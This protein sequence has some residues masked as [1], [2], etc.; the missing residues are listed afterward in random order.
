MIVNQFS[1]S[2]NYFDS[3]P[4]RLLLLSFVYFINMQEIEYKVGEVIGQI[5]WAASESFGGL[6]G[7]EFFLGKMEAKDIIGRADLSLEAKILLSAV[8]GAVIQR[9]IDS[10]VAPNEIFENG[11][12]KIL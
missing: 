3:V 8:A 9:L 1:E 11:V 4:V 6:T 10:G 2:L 12:F 5:A 7:K